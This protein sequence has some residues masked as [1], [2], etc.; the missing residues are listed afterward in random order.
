MILGV[1]LKSYDREI[2]SYTKDGAKMY[3]LTVENEAIIG[4]LRCMS[5][6]VSGEKRTHIHWIGG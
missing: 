2:A 4:N 5:V 3:N 6:E 1:Y